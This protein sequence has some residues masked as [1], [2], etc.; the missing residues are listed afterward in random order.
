VRGLKKITRIEDPF[1]N[2]KDPIA[3]YQP[4]NVNVRRQAYAWGMAAS[5]ALG[6]KHLLEPDRHK[7]PEA[8]PQIQLPFARR[9]PFLSRFVVRDVAAGHGFSLFAATSS[10][11]S[12]TLFGTG[13]N[14]YNQ[15]GWQEY[16][17]KRLTVLI[18][19]VPVH[20]PIS[21]GQR[22][23]KVAAGRCHSLALSDAGEVYSFGMN[24]YGQLGRRISEKED[25]TKSCFVHRV[26]I[27]EMVKDIVCGQDHSLFLTRSGSVYSCGLGAD[28]Q[29]GLGH[30][31]NQAD[32]MQVTGDLENENIIQV[33]SCA[34]SNLAL[35]GE[36]CL[37]SGNAN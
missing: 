18:E 37:F 25:Y 5:G 10:K 28:G 1:A 17:G 23:D 6:L 35:N 24:A 3:D 15:I 33:S 20:V 11:S 32:P 8:K 19:P 30:F 9:V 26:P 22:I 13:V 21:A 12:H 31:N 29:T 34:D 14:T 27:P 36:S 7:F 2:K 4:K 16:N